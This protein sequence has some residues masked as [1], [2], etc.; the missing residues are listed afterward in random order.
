MGLAGLAVVVAAGVG[1]LGPREDRITRENFH[2][3]EIG[4]SRAEVEAILNDDG[5]GAGTFGVIVQTE[6]NQRVTKGVK[7]RG[8]NEPRPSGSDHRIWGGRS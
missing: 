2:R 4:M 7:V 1:G 8:A 6:R 5:A 3:I